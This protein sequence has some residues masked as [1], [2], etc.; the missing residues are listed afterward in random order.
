MQHDV[1]AMRVEHAVTNLVRELNGL[2]YSEALLASAEVCGRII[3]DV[4]QNPIQ[5]QEMVHH[6]HQHLVRTIIAGAQAKGFGGH[7]G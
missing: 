6:V 2:A 7:Y 5:M 3:V 4:C 1:N